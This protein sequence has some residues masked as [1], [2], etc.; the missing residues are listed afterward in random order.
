MKQ[1]TPQTFLIII[2]IK[3]TTQLYIVATGRLCPPPVLL[4]L[5]GRP[6]VYF[7]KAR[8]NARLHETF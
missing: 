2:I 8:D 5:P 3:D 4:L 6:M 1:T 7:E